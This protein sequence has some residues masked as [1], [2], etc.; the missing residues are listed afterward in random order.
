MARVEDFRLK[1][2]VAGFSKNE[3]PYEN[4]SVNSLKESKWTDQLREKQGFI[5]GCREIR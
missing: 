2:I 4:Q 1:L 5:D 3:I